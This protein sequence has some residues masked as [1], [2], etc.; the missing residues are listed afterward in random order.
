VSYRDIPTVQHRGMML[1]LAYLHDWK[2]LFRTKLK[3]RGID[4]GESVSIDFHFPDCHYA[5]LDDAGYEFVEWLKLEGW[6]DV[7]AKFYGKRE[8]KVRKNWRQMLYLAPATGL[9]MGKCNVV[10]SVTRPK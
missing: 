10:V 3:A 2:E 7:S 6:E 4:P 1:K 8:V 5:P 9:E